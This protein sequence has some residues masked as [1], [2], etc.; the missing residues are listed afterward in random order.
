VRLNGSTTVSAAENSLFAA[1]LSA[2][3]ADGDALTFSFDTSMAGGG[4]AGGMFVIDNA[5]KQLRL[6]LGRGLDFESA[7]SLTIYV[8]AS[9]GRGVSAVQALTI[10]VTDVVETP[11][12]QILIGT[13]KADTLTGNVGN[14][15]LYGKL[16]KDVLTGGA[17]KDTFVFDTKPNK[18]KNLDKIVDY[19]VADDTLWLDNKIFK[20]LGKKGSEAA[21]SM[22]AKKFFKVADKAKDKNDYL[23]YN[24]KTGVLSYDVDGSGSAKAVE[25]TK[26]AKKLKLTH[27]DFFVV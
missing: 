17:G 15:S 20:K 2:S 16:G 7:Q 25:I 24:K 23:V 27:N 3:D 21:P 6:A 19:S 1:T 14:D 22:L 8:K 9:D 4:S 12:G 13:S 10:N 5:T 18:R 26:L 11:A